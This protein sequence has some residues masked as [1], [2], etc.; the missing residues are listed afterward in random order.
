[1]SLDLGVATRFPH[2]RFLAGRPDGHTLDGVPGDCYRVCVAI[3]LD[4]PVDQVPHFVMFGTSCDDV[5]RRF[6]RDVAPGSD[7]GWYLP[8]PWPLVHPEAAGF[9]QRYAIATGPSP[10]GPFPHC[11][12][13]DATTGDFV[14]D[15]HPS[16][17]GLVGDITFVDMIVPAYEPPPA[18]PI[19]LPGPR[20]EVMG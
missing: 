19:A 10:R 1:M 2:Q 4:L 9:L 8:T 12:V 17:D 5:V 13:V 16:G 20:A 14:H 18:A 6:V 3:L 15:P 7:L 11:V